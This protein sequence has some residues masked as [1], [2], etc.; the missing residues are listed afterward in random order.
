[1]KFFNNEEGRQRY[2]K[3]LQDAMDKN[4]LAT[5]Y[6]REAYRQII[7]LAKLVT[8]DVDRTEFV[9]AVLEI[10]HQQGEK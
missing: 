5:G 8:A 7:M 10:K 3:T 2:I 6:S 1:M 4:A 9:D